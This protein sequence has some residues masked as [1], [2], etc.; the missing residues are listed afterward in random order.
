MP[1]LAFLE[2]VA[3]GCALVHKGWADVVFVLKGVAAFLGYRAG[4]HGVA[5]LAGNSL[6]CAS[7]TEVKRLRSKVKKLR[8]EVS[9]L[10]GEVADLREAV[11]RSNGQ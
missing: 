2:A 1:I 4:R 7:Q 8:V 11:R 6:S 5:D 3:H 9:E 10:R